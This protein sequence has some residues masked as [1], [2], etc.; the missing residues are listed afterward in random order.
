MPWAVTI[1]ENERDDDLAGKL[2]AEAPGIL[3]WLIDGARHFIAEGLT[4]PDVV[5]AATDAYR[6]DEDVVG[7]FVGEV[8]YFTS[9][10]W[11]WSKAILDEL[12]AWC[13]EHGIDP[14]PTMAGRRHGA[15]RKRCT[16]ARRA[17]QGRRGVIWRGVTI[18]DHTPLTRE[19]T[20]ACHPCHPLPYTP[21]RARI[22]AGHTEKGAR[23]GRSSSAARVAAPSSAR[24]RRDLAA[25]VPTSRPVALAPGTVRRLRR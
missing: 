9:H 12:E 11:A 5:R 18:V 25:A 22:Y 14:G 4:P 7:R 13:T 17:I 16:S 1:P 3:C 2:R 6:A 24:G 23:G 21:P 19:N 20:D 10:G 15:E 8:L